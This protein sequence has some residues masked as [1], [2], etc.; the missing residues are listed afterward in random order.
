MASRP[1]C[2]AVC[3]SRIETSP[4]PD[5]RPNVVLHPVFF[6]LERNPQTEMLMLH[7]AQLSEATRLGMVAVYRSVRIFPNTSHPPNAFSPS[8]K[9]REREREWDTFFDTAGTKPFLIFVVL[10]Y[11]PRDSR[12]AFRATARTAMQRRFVVFPAEAEEHTE[13]TFRRLPWCA[14]LEGAVFLFLLRPVLHLL[15]PCLVYR[16]MQHSDAS[17]APAQGGTVNSGSD[18]RFEISL[19]PSP[20]LLTGMLSLLEG[21]AHRC[22]YWCVRV[23]MHGAGKISIKHTMQRRGKW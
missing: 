5:S 20:L 1:S 8:I 15:L 9:R 7:N 2:V 12:E 17:L 21:V 10:L 6:H 18:R 3:S 19:A 11:C 14:R 16:S 13:K 23:Y 4:S 22:V